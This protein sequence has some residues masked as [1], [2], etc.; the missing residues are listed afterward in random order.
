M[1]KVDFL[2]QYQSKEWYETSKR[3]KARDHN[4]CQMCGRNDVPLSVH[5]RYY[6][7]NG[8]L[9]VPDNALITLCEKCHHKETISKQGIHDQLDL[10][11]EECNHENLSMSFLNNFLSWI[12]TTLYYVR[13]GEIDNINHAKKLLEQILFETDSYSDFVAIKKL[14]FDCCDLVQTYHPEFIEQYK[15]VKVKN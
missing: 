4:T 7:E 15:N 6:G 10:L 14:G 3:I 12:G 13:H 5:H 9:L 2:K 1:N 11:I 8:S